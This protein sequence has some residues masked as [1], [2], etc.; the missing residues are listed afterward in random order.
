LKKKLRSWDVK[1]LG[2]YGC[3]RYD[4]GADSISAQKKREVERIKLKKI[5]QGARL[6]L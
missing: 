1:K 4:V 2:E 5:T 3:R 6:V